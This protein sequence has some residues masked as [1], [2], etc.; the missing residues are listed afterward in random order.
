MKAM[1]TYGSCIMYR[2]YGRPAFA[3]FVYLAPF[4]VN[5]SAPVMSCKNQSKSNQIRLNPTKSNHY[6]F[7]GF[8]RFT[9]HRD[10]GS[11]S[12]SALPNTPRGHASARVDTLGLGLSRGGVFR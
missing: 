8:S 5:V 11:L 1:G 7:S 4:V 3:D 12:P 10:Q 2:I 9:P 6:F